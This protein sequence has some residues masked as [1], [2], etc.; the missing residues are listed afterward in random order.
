MK[1]FDIKNGT[2][3]VN[4]YSKL[5]YHQSN[6]DTSYLHIVIRHG[7]KDDKIIG[8]SHF[9]EHIIL[10]GSV[11]YSQFSISKFLDE[12]EGELNAY[13]SAEFIEITAE[14]N[15]K[16]ICELI[17]I[18]LDLIF[19]NKFS[20]KDFESEKKV[21]HEERISNGYDSE[22]E[23][24]D[25]VYGQ[26]LYNYPEI[27]RDIIGNEDNITIGQVRR[28]IKKI[29]V[30]ENLIISITSK[31]S[32]TSIYR[33]VF[34]NVKDVHNI[35]NV[36]RK[37]ALPK[38]TDIG[39]STNKTLYK[40]VVKKSKSETFLS[41][42]FIGPRYGSN[43]SLLLEAGMSI[44]LGGTS[45]Y[46]WQTLRENSGMVYSIDYEVFYFHDFSICYIYSSVTK[47][48]VKKVIA[49]IRN[50]LEKISNGEGIDINRGVKYLK[51]IYKKEINNP[52][53][54]N[55]LYCYDYYYEDKVNNYV[56]IISTIS[57]IKSVKIKEYFKSIAS[58][59]IFETILTS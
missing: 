42:G 7:A 51:S 11:N 29:C 3:L 54:M 27:S 10:K 28:F 34:N 19:R 20:K 6:N 36:Q 57:K 8:L 32:Y 40:K 25:L 17:D 38:Y 15:S 53:V 18:V 2:L 50:S 30:P 26:I 37:R 55:K 12:N 45:S 41:V 33:Q 56:D 4:K 48:N 23:L 43:E 21:I 49:E 31:A 22:K 52:G 5:N 46:L 59:D 44:L 39:H 9:V 35:N 14:I 13:T 58:N 24:S 1:V 16:K 47:R